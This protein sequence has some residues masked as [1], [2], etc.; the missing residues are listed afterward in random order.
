MDVQP[1]K[2]HLYCMSMTCSA[3]ILGSGQRT[4]VAL[5]VDNLLTNHCCSHC[6][7]LLVS[8]VDIEIRKTLSGA[9]ILIVKNY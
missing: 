6:G 5:S 4:E 8:A 7:Q 9:G 3:S 1:L 2:F